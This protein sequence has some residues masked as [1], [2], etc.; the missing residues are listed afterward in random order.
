MPLP[1]GAAAAFAGPLFKGALGLAQLVRSRTM[2]TPKR[3]TYNIP[4]PIQR[5]LGQREM[6]LNSRMAGAAQAEE[7]IYQNQATAMGNVRQ[8]AT[9]SAALLGSAAI[10]QAQSNRAMTDLASQE[11]VDYQRRLDGLSQAQNTMAGYQDKQWDINEYEPYMQ[12]MEAK[13]ALT[14]G[15]LMNLYGGLS[16]AGSVFGQ[17]QAMDYLYPGMMSNMKNKPVYEQMGQLAPIG[18]PGF[19]QLTYNRG[20]GKRPIVG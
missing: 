15:G 7:N 3:P 12:A 11:A 18:A 6:N 14:Q 13:S 1:L 16:E 17:M 10:A 2:R 4:E 8:G 19:Q 9:N 20:L 5:Q